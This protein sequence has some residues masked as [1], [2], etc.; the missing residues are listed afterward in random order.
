MACPG[1]IDK[2]GEKN[3]S[4]T[5]NGRTRKQ[6]RSFGYVGSGKRGGRRDAQK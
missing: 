2:Q 1:V 5:N 4:V 6:P 3:N